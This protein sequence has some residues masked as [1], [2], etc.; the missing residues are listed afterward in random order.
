GTSPVA[1]HRLTRSGSH[2]I[3]RARS[4]GVRTRAAGL[5]P[6]M[7]PS[8]MAS[9][10]ALRRLARMRCWVALPVGTVLFDGCP[11]LWVV[12]VLRRPD[13]G[14]AGFDGGEHRA[15]VAGPDLVEGQV[16]QVRDVVHAHM[17]FVAAA[18]VVVHGDGRDPFGQV[19]GNGRRG[20]E[21]DV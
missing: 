6:A 21:G 7:S 12:A 9:L 5:G 16:S 17:R 10:N 19:G 1:C 11:H 20:G 14:V 4:A 13:G 15:Y 18:G 8:V 2:T 3:G